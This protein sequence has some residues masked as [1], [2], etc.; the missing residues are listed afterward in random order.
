[1]I[2]PLTKNPCSARISCLVS[3]LRGVRELSHIKPHMLDYP[4]EALNDTQKILE[5]GVD[6]LY[7]TNILKDV[8]NEQ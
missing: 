4:I 2:P 3:D 7:A 8:S 6:A 5:D 1:M